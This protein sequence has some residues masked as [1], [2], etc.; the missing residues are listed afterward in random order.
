MW[1]CQDVLVIHTCCYTKTGSLN[2]QILPHI[3]SGARRKG[4]LYLHGWIDLNEG[5]RRVVYH[6]CVMHR[7]VRKS[8][9]TTL[10]VVQ[11]IFLPRNNTW[12]IVVVNIFMLS[13]RIEEGDIAYAYQQTILLRLTTASDAFILPRTNPYKSIIYLQLWIGH[14]WCSNHHLWCQ[15]SILAKKLHF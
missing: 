9:A 13:L 15:Y 10:T 4:I 5:C 8:S 11:C 12:N 3:F 2:I 1:G 7:R 6:C 14:R